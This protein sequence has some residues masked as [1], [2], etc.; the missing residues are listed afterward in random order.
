SVLVRRRRGRG[1]PQPRH[2]ECAMA[3]EVLTVVDAPPVEP[4]TVVRRPHDRGAVLV[5]DLLEVRVE[6]DDVA[7]GLDEVRRDVV[8]RAMA[9]R[10]PDEMPSEPV[11]PV[12]QPP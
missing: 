10:P 12:A 3:P 11:E 9:N 2:R 7:G 4:P 6:L 1:R 5:V 8:P